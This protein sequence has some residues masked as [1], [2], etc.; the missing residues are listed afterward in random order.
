MMKT[1]M[2]L[3]CD[4]VMRTL[5]T[6]LNPTIAHV[7]ATGKLARHQL[8]PQG[9]SNPAKRLNGFTASEPDRL[10]AR[11]HC[12]VALWGSPCSQWLAWP[13]AVQLVGQW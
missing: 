12:S 10:P 13:L 5:C 3:T 4:L 2:T 6:C 8:Q 9:F 1:T 7:H 11:A